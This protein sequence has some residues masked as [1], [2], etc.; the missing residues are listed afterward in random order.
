MRIIL[1]IL[2]LSV[3]LPAHAAEDVT[4][5]GQINATDGID[6]DEANVIARE[7]F[8]RIVSACGRLSDPIEENG[9]YQYQVFLGKKG[10][11]FAHPL[12][13]DRNTGEVAL[14][15]MFMPLDFKLFEPKPPLD[16]ITDVCE[17]ADPEDILPL[18]SWLQREKEM[19]VPCPQTDYYVLTLEENDYPPEALPLKSHQKYE[20]C[21]YGNPATLFAAFTVDPEAKT[22]ACAEPSLAD[23]RTHKAYDLQSISTDGNNADGAEVFRFKL[24]SRHFAAVIY[25]TVYD[26]SQYEY[27]VDRSYEFLRAIEYSAV[28]CLCPDGCE[29]PAPSAAAVPEI[30]N[31]VKALKALTVQSGA[32]YP[33]DGYIVEIRDCPP[34]PPDAVCPTCQGEYIV[35]ADTPQR[36]DDISGELW[37]ST[38]MKGQRDFKKWIKYRFILKADDESLPDWDKADF[39]LMDLKEGGTDDKQTDSK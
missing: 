25:T 30:R 20:Y 27:W 31:S 36:T 1:I 24:F 3:C 16:E 12:T 2:W 10:K 18:E 37:V 19:Y 29:N 7:S 6:R 5:L 21:K 4:D 34:C 13:V 33:V 17:Q 14:K 38:V 32:E 35:I 22:E 26:V 28:N 11:S 39:E 15:T 8:H 23:V 9:S